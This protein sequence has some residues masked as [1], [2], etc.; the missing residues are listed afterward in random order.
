MRK[1]MLAIAAIGAAVAAGL[2]VYWRWFPR[3]GLRWANET[4]NPWLVEH[5][6]SGAG[7]S[8]IGTLE[9][10]GRR[11]G[12]RH[13]TPV[14]PVPTAEG[15]RVVVPLAERSEWARN[16]LAAGHCRVQFQDAVYEL[17]E[18]VLVRPTDVR[19]LQAPIRWAEERLGF[20]YLLL[21]RFA[22]HPGELEPLG[23]EPL[24]ETPQTPAH[25][26]R[27]AVAVA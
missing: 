12:T 8:E 21:H 14:H 20:E 25:K 19:E 27:K 5:G 3:A 7:R 4:M 1:T 17:D 26:P 6:L 9:H 23:T 10:Y 15:F 22:E 18:P 2:A 24:V 16:V 11:T 13:L